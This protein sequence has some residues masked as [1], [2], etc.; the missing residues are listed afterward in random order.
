MSGP[1]RAR[2]PTWQQPPSSPAVPSVAACCGHGVT[3]T[4]QSAITSQEVGPAARAAPRRLAQPVHAAAQLFSS[5]R[6][7]AAA[8]QRQPACRCAAGWQL[9]STALSAG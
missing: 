9:P 1:F 4:C 7:W 3:L 2:L 6:Q 8:L 5:G